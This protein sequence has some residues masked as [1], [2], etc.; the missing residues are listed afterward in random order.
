MGKVQLICSVC[1]GQ[2]RV[3]PSKPSRQLACPHCGSSY[4]SP[5]VGQKTPG[6]FRAASSRVSDDPRDASGDFELETPETEWSRT[7][8]LPATVIIGL[9]LLPYGVPIFWL[10]GP[11]LTGTM[12]PVSIATP[13]ALAVSVSILCVSI[14]YT[15][16]WS[17]ETRLKGVW[18]LIVLAYFGGLMLFFTEKATLERLYRLGK[19]VEEWREFQPDKGPPYRLKVP[20]PPQEM[21]QQPLQLAEL[22]CYQARVPKELFDWHIYVMGAGEPKP[23]PELPGTKKWFEAAG[24]ALLEGNKIL[25][26]H[27]QADNGFLKGYLWE[28]LLGPEGRTQIVLIYVGRG[29]VYYLAVEGQQ[30]DAH[31]PDVQRFFRSFFIPQ[32]E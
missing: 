28:F 29:K 31:H 17:A 4:Q 18:V 21:A 15:V 32:Q 12:P 20:A 26:R 24:N 10:I 2:W 7:G 13:L 16:D 8:G 11:M 14:I 5:P 3:T 23:H 30:I 1:G 27:W 25:K 22:T 6:V 19:E 9:A